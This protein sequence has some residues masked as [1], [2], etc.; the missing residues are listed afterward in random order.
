MSFP[1]TLFKE[2][3]IK[4]R[5]G[6]ECGPCTACCTT[7][8]VKELN[9][10]RGTK[11]VHEAGCCTIYE[12]RPDCCRKFECMWLSGF[13][14]GDERRRPNQLGLIFVPSNHD[15]LP[16]IA[17]WECFAGAAEKNIHLLKKLA[18]KFIVYV[19]PFGDP[20]GWRVL[21]PAHY[22]QVIEG[23]LRQAAQMP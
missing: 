15:K 3:T 12:S 14:E 9:K 6:R 23:M 19:L 20:I 10:E 21:G 16:I 22:R 1:L 17:C 11:C 5:A 18:T 7:I 2:Q 4:N 13:I 8:A